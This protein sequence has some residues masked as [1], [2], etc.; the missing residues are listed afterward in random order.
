MSLIHLEFPALYHRQSSV[1]RL[2]PLFVAGLEVDGPSLEEAT[3]E[4]QKK[5]RRR[6]QHKPLSPELRR[7]LLWLRFGPKSHF[8]RQQFSFEAGAH[9]IEAKFGV[10]W[11]ELAGT[12]YVYLPGFRHFFIGGREWNDTHQ[13]SALLPQVQDVLRQLYRRAQEQ[14]G[15][16]LDSLHFFQRHASPKGERRTA[17]EA[18]VEAEEA[19]FPFGDPDRSL[20]DDLLGD[21]LSFSGG[22]ELD[23]VGEDL[24]DRYPRGLLRAIERDDLVEQVRNLVFR[25]E[26]I[27]FVLVGP[28]G[29][30]KSA[31]LHEALFRE[32]DGQPRNVRVRSQKIWHLDPNR[33][34]A[35]MAVVGAWQRRLTAIIQY[36]LDRLTKL[37]PASRRT[38]RLYV[39]NLVALLTLGRSAHNTLTMADVLK[40]YLE[41]RSLA[42]I[43]ECTP[44]EWQK[45]QE[46]NRRFADLFQVIPVPPVSEELGV[47]IALWH[48]RRLERSHRCTI[49]LEAVARVIQ[50]QRSFLGHLALPGGLVRQLEELASRQRGR[51]RLSA[52]EVQEGFQANCGLRRQVFDRTRGLPRGYWETAFG[53][54]VGQAAA[55]NALIEVCHL[56]KSGLASPDRPCGS[57]LFVGPTGVGKTEAAKLLARCLFEKEGGFI[58]F[59]M[60]EYVDPEAAG[61]LIGDFHEPDGLLTGRV[62]FQPY[63]VLLFDEIEKAHPDVLDL[64]LQLLGE[65][66]L[67]DAAGRTVDFS[68]TVV[69]LTSNLGS[70]EALRQSGFHGGGPGQATAYRQAL[71]KH[72]RP[73]FLNRIDRTIVFDP[74]TPEEIR[75]IAELQLGQ[76]LDREG[77]IRRRTVLR[78]SA[79]T[80]D[81]IAR[82]GFDPEMGGRALRRCLEKEITTLAA[83][84]L[85]SLPPEQPILFEIFHREGQLLP[86]VTALAE[87][88]PAEAPGWDLAP[89]P[90]LVKRRHDAIAERLRRLRDE[91]ASLCPDL[92]L[93]PLPARAVEAVALRQLAAE[94]LSGLEDDTWDHEESKSFR[95]IGFK[96][97]L[98][99]ACL[100]LR[101]CASR[102]WDHSKAGLLRSLARAVDEQAYL[103]ELYR[104]SRQV[105]D[106][107]RAAYARRFVRAAALDFLGEGALSGERDSLCLLLRLIDVEKPGGRQEGIGPSA[108]RR[109]RLEESRESPAGI[110][111]NHLGEA[112]RKVLAEFGLPGELLDGISPGEVWIAASGPR[113]GRLFRPEEG[114]HHFLRRNQ[115]PQFVQVRLTAAP[116]EVPPLEL[117]QA[118]FHRQAA[119]LAAVESGQADLADDPWPLGP[120]VRV[121]DLG[122]PDEEA[123]R[124]MTSFDLRSG[125]MHQGP[126][127]VDDWIQLLLRN[128]VALRLWTPAD[129]E[130]R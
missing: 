128:L 68:H 13:M 61:R 27:S 74:L 80:L 64:L 87:A 69:V 91:L 11:F 94:Q 66:R 51:G 82:L 107:A 31:L 108:Y 26:N 76:L 2:R 115:P 116:A 25:P 7:E 96:N 36:V 72:F 12:P 3:L 45:V 90:N 84:Q 67:T 114:V 43:G 42:L 44:G 106:Q 41:N 79:G 122:G 9:Q 55:V 105:V 47:R 6:F 75:Q 46:Q 17:V 21:V 109:D 77:F 65:G 5:I 88:E 8:D 83:G 126:L 103:Q 48:R 110:Y 124:P 38:D 32:L 125:L 97:T 118:Q 22:R 111:L 73:E 40:P 35:G 39:D 34:I 23:K 92:T 20:F 98:P 33:V 129:W 30:G 99:P 102:S 112:Y 104:H 24:A 54:L 113:L 49:L 70:R 78:A 29:A 63:G 127:S 95:Q 123:H 15:A 4:L 119:W 89:P 53:G 14:S 62:R 60:N 56:L 85:V 16:R 52:E 121:Y 57:L 37:K 58:R 71:E 28:A 18:W 93:N 10:A 86:R 117:G 120:V 19:E 81:H 101:R 100:S 50:L 130:E 59:N 1:C